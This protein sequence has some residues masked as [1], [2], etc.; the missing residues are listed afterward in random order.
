M[1]VSSRIPRVPFQ[2]PVRLLHRLRQESKP[3]TEPHR[4]RWRPSDS[5]SPSYRPRPYPHSFH[6]FVISITLSRSPKTNCSSAPYIS[7][8]PNNSIPSARPVSSSF[9]VISFLPSHPLQ[10]MDPAFQKA[11]R[12]LRSTWAS[13]SSAGMG[14]WYRPR[15]TRLGSDR[16]WHQMAGRRS[17]GKICP[18][19]CRGLP[20]STSRGNWDFSDPHSRRSVCSPLHF[21]R[22]DNPQ[23]KQTA[24]HGY[25]SYDILSITTL[26]HHPP[27]LPIRDARA[28]PR[29]HHGTDILF[30]F[31]WTFHSHLLSSI[32]THPHTHPPPTHSHSPHP[33]IPCSPTYTRHSSL[34]STRFRQHSVRLYND[35]C[36]LDHPVP[37]TSRSVDVFCGT[38]EAREGSGAVDAVGE[39]Y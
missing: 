26:L 10:R 24:R 6:H 18:L 7:H 28:P 2:R 30:V 17:P 3:R 21:L 34:S 22:L 11:A 1:D 16:R 9:C 23:R 25:E 12:R 32:S 35:H 8:A 15:S 37:R 39:G 38:C 27:S 5:T 14:P 4:R 13:S 31:P 20:H 29:Q 33:G 36:N 19:A